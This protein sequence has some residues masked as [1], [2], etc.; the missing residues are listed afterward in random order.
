MISFFLSFFSS[1][2]ELRYQLAKPVQIEFQFRHRAGE[3]VTSGTRSDRNVPRRPINDHFLS[4]FF[5]SSLATFQRRIPNGSNY[6]ATAFTRYVYCDANRA[7][8]DRSF[9]PLLAVSFDNRAPSKLQARNGRKAASGGEA[10]REFTNRELA[11]P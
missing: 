5:L 2:F 6:R 7:N 1:S 4:L 3:R 9:H 11:S 10:V 8:K